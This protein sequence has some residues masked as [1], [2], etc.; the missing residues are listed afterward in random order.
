MRAG[1]LLMHHAVSVTCHDQ[2]LLSEE[3]AQVERKQ[4][5]HAQ[6][7]QH[8]PRQGFDSSSSGVP[9][10]ATDPVGWVQFLVRKDEQQRAAAR[11]AAAA[12][13]AARH[14]AAA[15]PS[16]AAQAR[17]RAAQRERELREA[18]QQVL[19]AGL[20]DEALLLAAGAAADASAVAVV[21]AS[22]V[23]D[24]AA[25]VPAAPGAVSSSALLDEVLSLDLD[26]L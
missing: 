21:G 25:D 4:Q 1:Q 20:D 10:P 6:L 9:N 8:Q 15:A 18:Q 19:A 3:L 23:S 7:H 12:A 24:N 2:K 5:Q 22:P 13:A 26:S 11:A 16:K 17:Q 14:A